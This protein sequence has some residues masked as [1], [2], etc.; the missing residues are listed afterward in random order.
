MKLIPPLLYTLSFTAISAE[1]THF[2]PKS[3]QLQPRAEKPRIYCKTTSHSPFSADVFFATKSLS[4][5]TIACTQP[6]PQKPPYDE[7]CVV[8]AKY[9]TA[10]I[11]MCGKMGASIRCS[12]AVTAVLGLSKCID[13]SE[14]VGGS[15]EFSWG[16]VLVYHS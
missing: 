6:N 14:R 5:T 1:P 11:G 3:H 16:G 8:L 12:D 10:T 4:N 13:S 7:G 9:K 15:A 2:S